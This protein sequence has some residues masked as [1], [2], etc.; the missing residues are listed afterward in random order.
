LAYIVG[1]VE[2]PIRRALDVA[3]RRAQRMPSDV[4]VVSQRIV[5]SEAKSGKAEIAVLGVYRTQLFQ[6]LLGGEAHAAKHLRLTATDR[7]EFCFR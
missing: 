1:V 6:R 5:S 7:P 2:E 3:A 4:P